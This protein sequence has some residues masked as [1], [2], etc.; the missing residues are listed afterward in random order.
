MAIEKKYC[1]DFETNTSFL[2]V[3]IKD[4]KIICEE[5][6]WGLYTIYMWQQELVNKLLKKH[7]KIILQIEYLEFGYVKELEFT[8]PFKLYEGRAVS[9]QCEECLKN[10]Q[11]EVY[12][13]MLN[14]D[15]KLSVKTDEQLY[16][17]YL[18]MKAKESELKQQSDNIRK[19]LDKKI[20]DGMGN[21]PLPLLGLQLE[22]NETMKDSYSIED[23]IENKLLTPK[24][25]NIKIMQFRKD[26]KGTK[27]WDKLK[28]VPHQR[29][30]QVNNIPELL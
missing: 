6:G 15:F 29:K 3:E 24:N 13:K 26:I 1:S 21:L 14:E 17:L 10:A 2:D 11:C 19:I 18:L 4:N 7:D 25:C 9:P 23:A 27:H 22:I 16:N 12:Q 28:K 30:L 5:P 20:Q 8:K